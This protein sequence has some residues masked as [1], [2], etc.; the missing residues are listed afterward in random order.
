[1]TF[2]NTCD[3]SST[4][5]NGSS[6]EYI[7]VI[8]HRIKAPTVSGKWTHDTS[9]Q[10]LE[11]A[12]EFAAMTHTAHRTPHKM[13][14][15][16]TFT[17]TL[18][19]RILHK[20]WIGDDAENMKFRPILNEST[21]FRNQILRV[22]FIILIYTTCLG[23]QT[24]HHQVLSDNII[25]KGPVTWW[26]PVWGPKHVVQWNNKRY[27]T[28][29]IWLRKVVLYWVLV[30]YT[31]QDAKPK[32]NMKFRCWSVQDANIQLTVFQLCL[33]IDYKKITHFGE[34]I[35]C[36]VIWRD[37]VESWHMRLMV[38]VKYDVNI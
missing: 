15:A 19:C 18:S 10:E 32:N 25:E 11:G 12:I 6:A 16:V 31:Q 34:D 4:F 2:S 30:Y 37:W 23:P 26:W 9:L 27:N 33:Q 24:G 36:R 28:D 22:L 1:V 8:V 13:K 35:F 14:C 29:K 5:Q 7:H 38:V 21:T 3:A 20:T 17:C